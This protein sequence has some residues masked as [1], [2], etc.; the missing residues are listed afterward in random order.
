MFGA[1]CPHLRSHNL[2]HEAQFVN[3]GGLPNS[4]VT[5]AVLSAFTPLQLKAASTRFLTFSSK[6]I[7]KFYMSSPLNLF[8]LPAALSVN[9]CCFPP[10]AQFSIRKE[11]NE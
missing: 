7:L 2:C 4:C 9:V 1:S 6:I 5:K 11:K 8:I 10:E 3:P